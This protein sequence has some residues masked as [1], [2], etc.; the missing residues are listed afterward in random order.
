M[1]RIASRLG[2]LFLVWCI[3]KT[4]DS[5]LREQATLR[6]ANQVVT[7]E[8]GQIRL[9]ARVVR[10][11]EHSFSF[12]YS[13]TNGG[14][15]NAYVFNR[16]YDRIN[17]DGTYQTHRNLMYVE[18]EPV[19]VVLSKKIIPVPPNMDVEKPIVPCTTRVRPGET[20]SE[21][22]EVAF[23]VKP[24]T[25]YAKPP[26]SSLQEPEIQR[27]VWIDIGYLEPT[28]DVDALARDVRTTEGTAPYFYPVPVSSQKVLRVG[29]LPVTV[30]VVAPR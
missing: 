27:S 30:P 23:P 24:S 11:D 19:G 17:Q 18:M 20:L 26:T 3:V 10:L 13:F 7:A 6:A 15:R 8:S 2:A 29:P 9:E 5:S 28:R 21:V 25:P 4:P 14:S 22:I 12:S 1:V 16:L